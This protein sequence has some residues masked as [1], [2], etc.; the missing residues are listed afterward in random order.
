MGVLFGK[1]HSVR[2]V[3]GNALLCCLVPPLDE[4]LGGFGLVMKFFKM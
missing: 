3:G 2:E 1:P 4:G